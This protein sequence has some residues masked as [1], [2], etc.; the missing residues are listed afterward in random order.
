[1]E[2]V[3]TYPIPLNVKE[4]PQFLGLASFYCR[5]VPCFAETAAPLHHLLAKSITFDWTPE[6]QQAFEDL[7]GKLVSLPV[8]AFPDFDKSFV[9]ETDA[10]IQG[11]GAV[12]S[13]K[14]A[15]GKL[16]PVAYA[17]RSL[18]SNEESYAITNLGH[19]PLSV[20]FVRSQ[21][22]RTHQSSISQSVTRQHECIRE[23]YMLVEQSL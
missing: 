15:D 3:A 21:C 14:Q 6:C 20:L 11:L 5:F 1:M 2:A 7:K 18:A 4:V 9:L 22:H 19:Q 16:H 13:Q 8:L 12:L 23:A 10:S 17:S